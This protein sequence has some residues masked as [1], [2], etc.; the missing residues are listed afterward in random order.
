MYIDLRLKLPKF[1]RVMHML[2]VM[3]SRLMN[4]VDIE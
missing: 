1:D 3:P 2:R 4:A